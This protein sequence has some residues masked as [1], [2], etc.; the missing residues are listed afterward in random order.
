VKLRK[1]T[2][3]KALIVAASA[4]LMGLFFALVQSQPR[5]AAEPEPPPRIDYQ[6]FFAPASSAPAESPEPIPT[7]R[8]T[9]TRAS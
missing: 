8:H 6:R 2:G 3:A 5:T 7:P 9:R 4:S 1:Q